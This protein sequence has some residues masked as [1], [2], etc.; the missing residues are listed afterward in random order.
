VPQQALEIA[1]A[2]AGHEGRWGAGWSGDMAGSNNMG[3]YQCGGD[4]GGVY[5]KCVEHTD[6]RPNADGTQTPYK[7]TFRY[8]IDGTTPDGKSRSAKEAAVWDFLNS[9]TSSKR[10]D[11]SEPLRSGDI[12]EYARQGYN[13]HYF[14]SFN[15][16]QAGTDAWAGSIGE[17]L[18]RGVYLFHAGKK[19]ATSQPDGSWLTEPGQ[20]IPA[21]SPS[22]VMAAGR[23]ALYA[24]TLA[25]YLPDILAALGTASLTAFVPAELLTFR[26]N[27][28]AQG[29]VNPT[30]H[31]PSGAPASTISTPAP[32]P[33]L[34]MP[35]SPSLPTDSTRP[36]TPTPSV[37]RSVLGPALLV[38]A[39]AGL[40]IYGAVRVFR[41][42]RPRYG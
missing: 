15:L 17:I 31:A 27:F 20:T 5:F 1:L 6:S 25:D 11:L 34:P 40:F 21:G 35:L 8:Y 12:L 9:I 4:K 16:T 22:A 36:S 19:I 39:G 2:Q 42:S 28:V 26:S 3:G 23:V 30:W 18:R 37:T 24:H 29:P 10:F 41:H 33:S 32:W 13:H 14:E 7:V 38:S